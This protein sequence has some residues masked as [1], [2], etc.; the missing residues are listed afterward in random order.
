MA[1]DAD[2]RRTELVTT[3]AAGVTSITTFRYANGVLVEEAVNGTPL[4]RF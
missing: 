3:S 2:G 1:Y 4:R